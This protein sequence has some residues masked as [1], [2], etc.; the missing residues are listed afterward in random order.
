MS[1]D[2][3]TISLVMSS[4]MEFITQMKEENDRAVVIMGAANVDSLLKSLLERSM[5]PRLN[6]KSDE[7][8]DGDSPLSSFSAKIKT[9]Y[10]I[11]LIDREF[12]QALHTLR[13]IRNDFAHRIKGC[14]LNSPPHSDQV[15]HLIN[16]FKD[17]PILQ[18]LRPFFPGDQSNSRD[19][20]IVLSFICALLEMKIKHIPKRIKAN[21]ISIAWVPIDVGG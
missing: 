9:C 18:T 8:L 1:N 12:A 6:R 3:Q 13:K 7:L 21:P 5:L 15:D 16:Y 17:S 11:A 2:Q 4:V 19:F 10:R 20:R 14:D